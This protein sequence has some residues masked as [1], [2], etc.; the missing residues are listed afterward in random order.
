MKLL[1]LRIS[2]KI[3]WF[4]S[5][6]HRKREGY[7]LHNYMSWGRE[8]MVQLVIGLLHAGEQRSAERFSPV[9]QRW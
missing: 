9:C 6:E 7:G 3:A 1:Q 4:Y 5:E 2:S 8:E